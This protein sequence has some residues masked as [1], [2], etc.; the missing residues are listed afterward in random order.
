[1]TRIGVHMCATLRECPVRGTRGQ[2]LQIPKVA[3]AY[4]LQNAH[5]AVHFYR[6]QEQGLQIMLSKRSNLSC[7][8]M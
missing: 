5:Q 3:V 1:M 2:L 6:L 7:D 8:E 4:R